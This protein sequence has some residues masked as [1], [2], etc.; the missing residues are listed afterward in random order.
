[1][2]D[3]DRRLSDKIMIAHAQASDDGKMDMAEALLEALE[4]DLSAI[5]GNQTE[6]R[7]ATEKLEAAFELH[8]RSLAQ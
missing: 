4:V 7:E 6:N 5:G 3:Q 8:E 1:V 2:P